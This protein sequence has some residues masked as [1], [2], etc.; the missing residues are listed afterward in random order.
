MAS[1]GVE[2]SRDGGICTLTLDRPG[3]KNA[4]APDD[5]AALLGHLRSIDPGRDRVLVLRGAG[6]D[7]CAGA[8][9]SVPPDPTRQAFE[10]LRTV[11]DVAVTLHQLPIPTIAAVRG[12]AVGAGMNL[13]LCCDLVLSTPDARWA[14]IYSQRALS[15]DCGGS[16]LLPRL[17]GLAK[18]KELAV[19]GEIFDG[20]QAQE[21]GLVH[22]VVDPGDLDGAVH[23]L[24]ERLSTAP[25]LALGLTKS[26]LNNA[27]EISLEQ[28]CDAEGKSL[29]INLSSADTQEA[30]AAF[31][32][33]RTPEFRGH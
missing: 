6:G 20:R 7:F 22:R 1:D 30:K 24:A 31:R 17:I 9:L 28:A 25:T 27:F 23:A 13:A 19:L 5:W 11:G 4:L 32:E 14:Q 29:G 3:R 15:P 21:Y 8:D 2:L 12:V 26:M 18:A 33:K 16:W 10:R